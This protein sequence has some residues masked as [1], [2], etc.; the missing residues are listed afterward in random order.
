MTT[1][2]PARQPA[3]LPQ[4]E[5]AVFDLLHQAPSLAQWTIIHSSSHYQAQGPLR[6]IDFLALIPNYG[7]LCIEVKGGGFYVQAG[8]W[9]RWCNGASVEPPARQSEQAMYAL[10]HEL[11]QVYGSNSPEGSIPTECVVIF[12]DCNWPENVRRPRAT[13]IDCEDLRSGLFSTKLTGAAL[14]L[15]PRSGRRSRVPP[16]AP[17]TIRSIRN[18]LSPD[19][20]MPPVTDWEPGDTPQDRIRSWLAAP[21]TAAMAGSLAPR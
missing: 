11:Q 10:Q 14:S 18:Y 1:M 16:T 13:I 20:S 2:I 9:H 5:K 4:S 8:E 3:G 21:R 7:M 17:Q 6:E 19:F 15:R 12:T